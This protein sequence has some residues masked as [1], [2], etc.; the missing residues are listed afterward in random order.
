MNA[1]VVG[2]INQISNTWNVKFFGEKK[3]LANRDQ[4]SWSLQLMLTEAICTAKGSPSKLHFKL[5][6]MEQP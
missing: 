2:H 1:E 3:L 5:L 4:C 6:G